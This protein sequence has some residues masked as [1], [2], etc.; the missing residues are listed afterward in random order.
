[1]DR[2]I[3]ILVMFLVTIYLNA[4]FIKIRNY[5]LGD[6]YSYVKENE[7]T[8]LEE[9][10]IDGAFVRLQYSDEIF[11]LSCKV[12]FHFYNEVLKNIYIMFDP[13]LNKLLTENTLKE[14]MSY[15]HGD[16]IVILKFL[17]F[18]YGNE[19]YQ[20][21]KLLNASESYIEYYWS[22]EE[23][24]I[25]LSIQVTHNFDEDT[26]PTSILISYYFLYDKMPNNIDIDKF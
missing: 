8:A 9:E 4:N 14:N 11:G 6:T 24:N 2:R 3:I 18:K 7:R 26:Y 15:S 25:I 19:I 17:R 13:L 21:N 1:M 20:E 16:E 5:K 12:V 22:L 10:T 23:I